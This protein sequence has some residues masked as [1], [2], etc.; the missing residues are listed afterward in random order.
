MRYGSVCS[1][2]EAATV[3]WHQLGLEP[4]WFAEVDPFCNAVLGHRWPGV[5]NLGDITRNGFMEEAASHGKIDLLVGGTPCQSFSL[6]GRRD[7][8]DDPRGLLSLRF[9]DIAAAL[10]PEWV[11]W[12][13]VPGVL[14]SGGGRDFGAF[15]CRLAQLGYGWCYRVLDARHFGL[16]QTRRRVFV[17]GRSGGRC[18]WQVLA[19]EE[20][21][22]GDIEEL[23]S[24]GVAHQARPKEVHGEPA[25]WAVSR[26]V[27]F[28]G[29]GEGN[30]KRLEIGGVV[31]NALTANEGRGLVKPHVWHRGVIR[32]MTP[33]EYERLQG[34][35]IWRERTH[36]QVC[37][38]D[39]GHVRVVVRWHQEPGCSA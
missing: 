9:L 31:A 25:H 11:V 28:R 16:A 4:A 20:L 33:R 8:F 22:G 15:L 32:R 13:N 14:S 5:A 19:D 36:L 3:A 23:G 37:Q 30:L 34:F 21:S 35:P 17:I 12:E 6:V 39:Q 24:D 1:G 38:E 26:A 2:I 18:P 7:G 27:A 29:R 10:S